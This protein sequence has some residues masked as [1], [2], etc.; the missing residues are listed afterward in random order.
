M[1][2]LAVFLVVFQSRVENFLCWN[3][4]LQRNI[5]Y[6]TLVTC[7]NEYMEALNYAN[8]IGA[9]TM[10]AFCFSITLMS[11]AVFFRAFS[12]GLDLYM[13]KEMNWDDYVFGSCFVIFGATQSLLLY[14]LVL[15]SQKIVDEN[16]VLLD[17]IET[18]R[19]LEKWPM[20]CPALHYLLKRLQAF[21]GF[22]ANDYFYLNKPLLT[23][24]VAN[25]VTYFIILVQFKLG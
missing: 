10:L 2:A 6:Q 24:I 23:G 4:W 3:R 15:G 25:F 12:F 9:S 19:V 16:E 1:S 5:K 11:I 7:G 17:E 18:T 22:S 21:Q 14:L 8:E 13:S 20:D